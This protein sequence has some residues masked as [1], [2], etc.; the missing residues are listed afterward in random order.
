MRP[1]GAG[2]RQPIG[3]TCLSYIRHTP[4]FR[5]PIRQDLLLRDLLFVFESFTLSTADRLATN[6]IQPQ[7]A[8]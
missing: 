1:R 5:T 6:K 7:Q 3:F 2:A 8:P 4:N